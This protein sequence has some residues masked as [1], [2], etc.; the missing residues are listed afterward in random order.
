M[1]MLSLTNLPEA[2][3]NNIEESIFLFDIEGKLIFL[4]KAAEEFVGSPESLVYKKHYSELFNQL[5]DVV[6]LVQKTLIEG[7]L[8]NCKDISIESEQNIK[9]DLYL[10]P[11][12]SN[13][14]LDGVIVCIRQNSSLIE[15]A[16]DYHFDSLL[17]LLATIA[18]EIK[19]PLS[20]IKG[21]AQ[22]LKNE[23][24]NNEAR[25]YIDIIIKETDRLNRILYDY[26]SI[27]RK[28][29]FNEVNI[30]EVLEHAMKI[31][32]P[33]IKEKKI[34]IYKS[35]DPS[36]PNIRG[37]AGKLLQ[38]F[39][40][41]IKNSIESMED[42]RRSKR[43]SIFTKPA[44]EYVILYDSYYTNNSHL[45]PKKQ[46]WIIISFE[47]TG[48]GILHQELKK[49]F[50]PFYSKKKGGTGLGLAL[51]QKII[52]DHGG[53]IMAKT[54]KSNKGAIFNVYLPF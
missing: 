39:I 51:S 26:L 52:K 5:N 34:I 22:L 18:H 1:N 53:V 21:A 48:K 10:Y 12:Y 24:V 20:G 36:L 42:S 14:R 16:D 4:N 50:L 27:S 46:R 32:E 31:M 40:N 43:F 3:I 23:I 41:L 15:R 47:D 38:V 35:Y 19:N 25:Q 30:H 37:D 13:N 45:K 28:P 44:N 49:I 17:F 11:F 9:I 33:I 2:I 8:F 29:V 6:I 54:K 7:R